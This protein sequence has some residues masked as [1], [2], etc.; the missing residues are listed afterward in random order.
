MVKPL[1]IK[2]S[3]SITFSPDGTLLAA[4]ARDV[5]VWDL[6][7]ARK[8]FRV[9]PLS[10]P[11]HLC[12]SPSGEQLA[13]K[14]TSGLIV[15]IDSQTG[16]ELHAFGNIEDGEG[17]NLRYSPC[18]DYLVDGSWNGRLFVRRADSGRVEFTADFPGESI[19][20]VQCASDERLWAISHSPR[21]TTSNLPPD[22]DYFSVWSWPFSTSAYSIFPRRIPFVW[23]SAISPDGRLMIV[24]C[25]APPDTLAL[26][27]A[28]DGAEVASTSFEAGGTGAVVCWSPDGRFIG[29]VKNHGIMIYD[30]S[31]LKPVSNLSVPYASDIVFAPQGHLLAVGSWEA[32]YVFNLDDFD[33]LQVRGGPLSP[34]T[35]PL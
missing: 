25:G 16:K 33:G 24:V 8:K 13:I 30:S 7:S 35:T 14:G 23:A 11:S 3:Y 34:S 27:R 29:A 1:P 9:H 20:D 21:A 22:S 5:V 18:G 2:R 32:G 10:H 31:V 15:V 28:D 26:Y 17:S 6:A 4:L 19:T 12:F